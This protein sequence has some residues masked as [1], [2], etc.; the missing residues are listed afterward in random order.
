MPELFLNGKHMVVKRGH[1]L[2]VLWDGREIPGIIKVLQSGASPGPILP[3]KNKIT[4]PERN[5]HEL[6]Q[7]FQ[8]VI[9]RGRG[10][11]QAF[12]EWYDTARN[13]TISGD[14][15]KKDIVIKVIDG[16]GV[17]LASFSL[18]G[19]LPTML[20]SQPGLVAEGENVGMEELVLKSEGLIIEETK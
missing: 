14:Q 16:K 19:C 12:K 17:T 2:I 10:N 3:S 15:D 5:I 8:V 9:K 18:V 4:L 6:A 13:R 1:R 7:G 20:L 11:N